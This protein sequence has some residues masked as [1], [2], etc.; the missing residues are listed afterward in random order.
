MSN[1]EKLN[2]IFKE[3]FSVE[4][5]SLNS[6]FVNTD[7]EQWD[8]IHHLSLTAAVEEQFEI[9]LDPEDV[10][11]MVSYDKCKEILSGKYDITF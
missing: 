11:E 7:V 4:E 8:S 9:L 6:D 1:I 5:G 2:A 3:V 10:I